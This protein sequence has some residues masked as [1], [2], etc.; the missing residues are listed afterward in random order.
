MK[1][2]D[3]EKLTDAGMESYLLEANI[4]HQFFCCCCCWC[5]I[6]NIS[7]PIASHL[8]TLY[9]DPVVGCIISQGQ[10]PI[11]DIACETRTNY[12]HEYKS[13]ISFTFLTLN[14]TKAG[15]EA[16]DIFLPLPPPLM[17]NLRNMQ[18]SGGCEKPG[19][20]ETVKLIHRSMFMNKDLPINLNSLALWK[21]KILQIRHNNLE[22]DWVVVLH[23]RNNHITPTSILLQI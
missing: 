14:K 1:S 4:S 10:N 3:S 19:N 13:F 22:E 18:I 23:V 9:K 7:S 11:R 8:Q 6:A 20:M 16:C 15:N 5:N 12:V 21:K 17:N 2:S